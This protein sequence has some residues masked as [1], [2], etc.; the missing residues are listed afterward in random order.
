MKKLFLMLLLCAP[1]TLFAQTAK[2]GHVDAQAVMQSLPEFIKAVASW[3]L[4]QS[5]MRMI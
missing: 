5:S 2:F 4:S 3:R 1:L